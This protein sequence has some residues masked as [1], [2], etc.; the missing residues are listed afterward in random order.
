MQAERHRKE[1]TH[2]ELAYFGWF[3]SY[4]FNATDFSF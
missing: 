4:C 3:D 2:E 1:N